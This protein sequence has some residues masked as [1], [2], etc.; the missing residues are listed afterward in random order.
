MN[1]ALGVVALAILL[2]GT[3]IAQSEL[4]IVK[5]GAKEYHRPG[6][7]VVRD[8][9]GVVALTKAQAEARGLKPH[10]ACDP[11]T[12]PA[13]EPDGKTVRPVPPVY[14]Y[15]DGG[16]YYHR[17]DCRKLGKDPK[18][19]ALD[20]AGKE[21]WPCPTCRPPIRKRSIESGGR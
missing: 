11:A 7:E 19:V 5:K 8:G 6:C 15:T 13:A 4:V 9:E 10:A 21:Q 17:Q 14:V 20:Q 1:N 2:G 18:K 3:T 16:R 12:A